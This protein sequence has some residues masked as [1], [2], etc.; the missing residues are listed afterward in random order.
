MQEPVGH[1]R[2]YG[3]RSARASILR[4][5]WASHRVRE[6]C[7]V[8]AR[9]AYG[10]RLF[11]ASEDQREPPYVDRVELPNIARDT[12]ELMQLD[13]RGEEYAR[14][15]RQL[16]LIAFRDLYDW[17]YR[18]GWSLSALKFPGRLLPKLHRGGLECGDDL[19]GLPEDYLIQCC[20]LQHADLT[21]VSDRISGLDFP[22]TEE[23]QDQKSLF[24]L[25]RVH[26]VQPLYTYEGEHYDF[27]VQA[28][29]PGEARWQAYV[30]YQSEYLELLRN[31]GKR[32]RFVRTR[33]NKSL[34]IRVS[35]L[36]GEPPVDDQP[37]PLHT[38]F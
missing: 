20:R 9:L 13:N 27:C 29:L 38:L 30:R 10:M 37:E 36:A 34:R 18:R 3:R 15:V 4:E 5:H 28:V 24:W 25:A 1:Y 17:D 11:C 19:V 12:D 7:R 26:N 22:L 14:Y 16:H 35:A 32:R 6:R 33:L 31:A 21:Y 2:R 23:E 8:N